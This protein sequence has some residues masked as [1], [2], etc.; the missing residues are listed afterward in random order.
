MAC[1]RLTKEEYDDLPEPKPEGFTSEADCGCPVSCAEISHYSIT[2]GNLVLTYTSSDAG[3]LSSDE[4]CPVTLSCPQD[5]PR[6]ISMRARI[7]R[8]TNF[9]GRLFPVCNNDVISGGFYV[10]VGN[11]GSISTQAYRYLARYAVNAPATSG[12][13]ATQLDLVRDS[14]DNFTPSCGGTA[15]Y[16]PECTS[17]WDP[18]IS[19][20]PVLR[21]HLL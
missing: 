21:V 6:T 14:G 16:P 12:Q 17:F 9:G 7:A 1:K 20:E 13:I 2:W 3:S 8:I 19:S 5:F 15:S 4:F 18:Y 11:E 10:W